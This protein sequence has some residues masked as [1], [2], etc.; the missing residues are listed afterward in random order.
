MRNTPAPWKV[1][2][3][4]T[5]SSRKDT[6]TWPNRMKWKFVCFLWDIDDWLYDRGY[7]KTADIIDRFANWIA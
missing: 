7:E 1:G 6:R 2:S 3:Q 4:V 5:G